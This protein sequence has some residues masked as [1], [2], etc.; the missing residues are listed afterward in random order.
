MN[1]SVKSL[2]E[3]L[4]NLKDEYNRINE[5]KKDISN[6]LDKIHSEAKKEGYENLIDEK[7]VALNKLDDVEKF[8]VLSNKNIDDEIET[9]TKAR[10][11]LP[12]SD[13]QT[14][15][16]KD[17][18]ERGLLNGKILALAEVKAVVSLLSVQFAKELAKKLGKDQPIKRS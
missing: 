15:S 12:F 10:A 16:E 4:Q 18:R 5:K 2:K 14:I 6:P 9:H 11:T 13:E 8:V 7:I 1:I 17:V 3:S